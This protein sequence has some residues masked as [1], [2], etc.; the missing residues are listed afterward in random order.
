MRVV[1]SFTTNRLTAAWGNECSVTPGTFAVGVG[2]IIIKVHGHSPGAS[3][4]PNHYPPRIP[5]FRPQCQS[6]K[7]GKSGQST[8]K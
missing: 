7:A 2:L 8:S 5:P 3:R 6:R 4:F 1:R